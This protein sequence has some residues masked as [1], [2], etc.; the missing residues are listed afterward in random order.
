MRNFAAKTSLAFSF[1]S[2]KSKTFSVPII[3]MHY[4]KKMKIKKI[5]N[6]YLSINS[7][8]IQLNDEQI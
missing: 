6:V 8:K 2:C 1:A 7:K 5:K 4:R 3:E